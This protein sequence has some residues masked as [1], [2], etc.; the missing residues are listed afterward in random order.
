ME[1]VGQISRTEFIEKCVRI[2]PL[3]YLKTLLLPVEIEMQSDEEVEMSVTE[4]QYEILKLNI[5]N[6]L[7]DQDDY[8]EVF[9]QDMPY[10]D[11]P[12]L[13]SISENLADIYQDIMNFISVY[14]RGLPETMNDALFVCKENFHDFWGQN[15]VNVLRALHSLS[16]KNTDLY[17]DEEND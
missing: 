14:R 5:A 6:L 9:H 2:L 1:S 11:T 10:S 16:T 15:L 13:A 7:A 4:E 3:L 8:L 12:I 17:A